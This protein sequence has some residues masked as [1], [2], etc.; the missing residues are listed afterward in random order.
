MLLFW[1][2]AII[3][4]K[5]NNDA[6]FINKGRNEI[7]KDLNKIVIGFDFTSEFE[8]VSYVNGSTQF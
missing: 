7:E 8:S 2:F 1:F 5:I 4:A 3:L 6:V